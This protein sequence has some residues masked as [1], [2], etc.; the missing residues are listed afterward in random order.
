MKRK[1]N[2]RPAMKILTFPFGLLLNVCMSSEIEKWDSNEREFKRV[3]GIKMEWW[4]GL[5]GKL[6][7]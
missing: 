5:G 3:Y 7:K 1:E 6:K 4:K 2:Q